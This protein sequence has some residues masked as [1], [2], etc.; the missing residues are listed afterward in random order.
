M[1]TDKEVR[2]TS[3]LSQE[4]PVRKG[5]INNLTKFDAAFFGIHKRQADAMDPQ[6]RQIIECAYEAI[7]DAGMH[8]HM[9]RNSKTAVYVAVCFSE[10]EKSLLFDTVH[11][12]GFSLAG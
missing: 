12:D 11:A 2:W 10:T 5:V 6:G 3:S 9:L 4:I 8:P 1:I 7:L